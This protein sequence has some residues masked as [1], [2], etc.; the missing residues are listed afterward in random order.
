MFE[1]A[2]SHF[3]TYFS[4]RVGSP[5]P[6]SWPEVRQ[7]ISSILGHVDFSPA[8]QILLST[9]GSVTKIL[10]ILTKEEVYVETIVQETT[11]CAELRSPALARDMG[12][13]Y[14]EPINFRE[15][16]LRTDSTQ[17]AFAISIA[18]LSRLAS[19]FTYDLT[20]A[21]VPVGK[22]LTK[23]HIE[24]RRDIQEI[25]VKP[26]TDELAEAFHVAQ[27]SLVPYRY[28]NIIKDGKILMK[29]LE[30]FSPDL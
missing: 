3:A 25:G 18:P 28:Y 11:T 30:F 20:H 9:D 17:L 23:Y 24:S 29:I 8:L 7:E 6:L 16:W 14:L 15:V 5:E 22:L 21:D 4:E 12:L 13:D 26:A 2:I 19:D 10:E 27:E 1:D